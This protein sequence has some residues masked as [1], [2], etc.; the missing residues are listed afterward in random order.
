M[1]IFTSCGKKEPEIPEV[2]YSVSGTRDNTPRVMIP[3]QEGRPPEESELVRGGGPAGTLL[4]NEDVEVDISGLA[5]GYVSMRFLG[6]YP[7][8]K[9]RIISSDNKAYTYALNSD[10][11]WHVYPFSLGDGDYV[12]SIY[13]NIEGTM[14]TEVFSTEVSVQL[15]D[16]FGPFLYPNQY[17]WFASDS[18]AVAE[19]ARICN[20][21]NNDLEA[22]TYVFNYIVSNITYDWDEAENIQSDYLPQVDEV[23]ETHK[24]ICLDY[25]S[26]IASMLRTQG[27][28][29]RM[30]IG[31]AGTAYHAW[32]SCYI[33]EIGWVN[34]II[35]FDGKNWSMMDPTFTSTSN[36][37]G[38]KK[39]KEFIGDGSNYK[40]I[41]MY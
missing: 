6:D 12:L 15:E 9:V 1:L 36:Q 18:N 8:A 34:G 30:E 5:H 17:C 19:G 39:L 41:Y 20:P 40:T 7:R 26:L 10:G 22:V 28:P 13:G 29:T 14:Y 23:L 4:G 35:Q 37:K 38:D 27:I 25:A 32:I 3:V 21:A 11:T 16:E 2:D 33:K 24:G 31:Y